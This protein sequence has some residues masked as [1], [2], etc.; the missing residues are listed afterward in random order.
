MCH[1][2]DNLIVIETLQ[3][4]H[5][6]LS[7]K[8]KHNTMLIKGTRVNS[9]QLHNSNLYYIHPLE[10]HFLSTISIFPF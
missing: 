1:I 9:I 10:L 3:Q 7:P 6:A 8:L 5:D 2:I 4:K